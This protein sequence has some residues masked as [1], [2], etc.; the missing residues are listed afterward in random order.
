MLRQNYLQWV[1]LC[2][3]VIRDGG[4]G[5]CPFCR[6]PAPTSDEEMIERY[7]KRMEIDDVEAIFGLGSFYNEGMYGLPQDHNKA[8]ELWHRAAKL[9]NTASHYNIGGAHHRGDGVE[10]DEKKAVHYY[11]L[12]AMGGDVEA[13][14]NLGASEGRAGNMDRALKHYM[15]AA[16]G[17]SNKSLETIKKMFMHRDA[18]KDD[19]TKALRAYQAYLVEIK[20]AQRDEAAAF[21]D[22]NKYY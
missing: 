13:R 14:H 8:L 18:T 6:K 15:I 11:E 22:A 12:S 9:G 7:K 1:Y 17:G 19:Y 10:R 20:S 5:L 2:T 4:I 3:V 16:G 21:N